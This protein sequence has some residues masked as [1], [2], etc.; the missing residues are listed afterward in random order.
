MA[1]SSSLADIKKRNDALRATYTATIQDKYALIQGK[2]TS[3]LKAMGIELIG[4]SY[5]KDGVA[6]LTENSIDSITGRWAKLVDGNG[7]YLYP[8]DI[9]QNIMGDV[10]N[11]YGSALSK[12]ELIKIAREVYQ[13]T[14]GDLSNTSIKSAID[15]VQSNATKTNPD[16]AVKMDD[17]VTIQS[18]LVPANVVD[19]VSDATGVSKSFIAKYGV[20]LIGGAVVI[21]AAIF[22]IP[23]RKKS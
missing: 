10:V 4:G 5:F 12:D 15:T 21:I 14:G 19:T 3:E 23:K 18:S 11:Q 16:L 8:L 2:T 22:L 9:P 7:N 20:W 13:K 6:W 1:L 17:A